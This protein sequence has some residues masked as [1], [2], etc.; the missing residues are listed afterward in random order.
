MDRSKPRYR[1]KTKD[2]KVV[3]RVRPWLHGKGRVKPWV[4]LLSRRH[5]HSRSLLSR[6]R[7]L[8]SQRH[9]RRRSLQDRSA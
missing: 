6:R 1:L 5:S 8:L 4:V 9:H 7:N 3:V 2:G